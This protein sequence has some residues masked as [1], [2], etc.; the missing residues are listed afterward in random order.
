M[1]LHNL[2]QGSPEWKAYRAQHFNA[3][4]A[5]AM[6][7]ASPYKT[8]AELLRELHT[9][10]AADVDVGTQMRFDNGHKAEALARPLA[11]EFIGAELYPVTGSAGKL[12]ASFDGLTL[13]ETEGFE[14]KALNNGLRKAFAQIETIAPKHREEVGCRELPI[15]HRIQME[16]QLLISGAQRILFMASQWAADEELVEEQ[17]CWYYPD[18]ELRAQIVAGWEQFEKDLAAYKLAP[19]AVPA[20]TGKAPETLPALLI[21]VT[22]K[23]TASNLAEFKATALAAINSI[24]RNLK[25]DQDFSDAA[26]AV[27][28]CSDIESRLEAAKQHALSQTASIDALF[29]AMDDIGAEA[30]RVRLDLDKLVTRRK[31]EVK[32]EALVVARNALAAHYT[33]LNA[34]LVPAW[35]SPP[36]PDFAGAIK[37]LRSFDS[38]QDALDTLLAKSKIDA[39]TAARCVR[40]NQVAFKE[41]AAGFEFLFGD[42]AHLVHKAPDDFAAALD[43][44]ISQHKQAEAEKEEQQRARIRAEEGARQQA[45]RQRQDR[46]DAERKTRINMRIEQLQ[47]A[48]TARAGMTAAQIEA[49]RQAVM[50]TDPSED[51]YGDRMGEAVALRSRV[52]I[53]LGEQHEAA[54]QREAAAAK[55]APPAPAPAP[56]TQPSQPSQAS[57]A[58]ATEP[59]TLKLGQINERLGYVVTA[60]LLGRLGFAAHSDRSANLYRE[61]D[62]K[63]ICAALSAHTLTVAAEP[64]VAA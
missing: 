10:V 37:G 13:D 61:G 4:D 59:P 42:L 52:L 30:R 23:V 62:F 44:R 17:H 46:L 1:K 12:S 27:K 40:T 18:H 58:P 31:T 2:I 50:G 9:G 20:P 53:A 57:R 21:E 38:M 35:L 14:H 22:G 33:T 3:S 15:Y 47:D 25:T 32:E 63:A 6:M 28:W 54:A 16:Q 7:G 11:E 43:G 36:V 34:E 64:K 45:E 51:L 19:A 55:A 26:K 5:P 49:K 39:D 60:D 41:K 24:N 48:L 29:K 8:R 56:A